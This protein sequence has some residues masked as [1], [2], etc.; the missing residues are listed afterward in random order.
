MIEKSFD[1]AQ[2]WGGEGIELESVL[3]DQAWF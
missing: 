3:S 1:M 2:G